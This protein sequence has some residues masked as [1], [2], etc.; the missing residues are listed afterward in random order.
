M[1][2][3]I[4]HR[5]PDAFGIYMD[6]NA[7]LAHARLSIIDL[8]GGD[9][10]I[11]N[12]DRSVWIVYNGEVF[13]YPELRKNLQDRGHSFYTQTD[14][15]IIVHLYEEHGPALFEKLN[16][17]FALA[18]WDQRKKQLILG[19]D[20]VGIRPL[21]YYLKDDR[22][23]FGSEIKALFADPTI[24]RK[25]DFQSLSDIFTCWSSF[26]SSTP[27]QNIRQLLPGHYAMFSKNGIMTDQYWQ[28]PAPSSI[29]RSHSLDEWTEELQELICDATR[30]RL[31]ADVPV[32]SYLSGGI[33]STYVSSLVKRSFNNRLCTFS[34]RFTNDRFDE[35]LFQD[36]AIQDLGTDHKSVI[37]A[38]EDIGRNFPQVI[39]HAETPILRTAPAP[40][41][42]LSKLVR[43]N[44]FKV[45]LTGEGAD[46]IFAGYNIFKED[47]VRRFWARQPE[48]KIRPRLLEKLYP[49]IFAQGDTPRER[50]RNAEQHTDYDLVRSN[51]HDKA[52]NNIVSQ[53]RFP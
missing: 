1:L 21:F 36:K 27:F 15:E 47:K 48:S 22:L 35:T 52:A 33:D 19:R 5:G 34:V 42:Q 26:G 4:R 51:F 38:D 41:F 14:T 46:E 24:P 8:S 18:I 7:G 40:L 12:E 6:D 28:L 13:N 30:I 37:C 49:Y 2:G 39:W 16:G 50:N 29:G 25:I 45:V 23:V 53:V 20:R 43:E 9:Q 31:R 11:H 17:Q 10:P 3:L 44:D 32:G